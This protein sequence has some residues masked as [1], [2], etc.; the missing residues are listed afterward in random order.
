M[1]NTPPICLWPLFLLHSTLISFWNS[2]LLYFGASCSVSIVSISVSYL[3]HLL[4]LSELYFECFVFQLYLHNYFLF[5]CISNLCFFLN[6]PSFHPALQTLFLTLPPDQLNNAC[7]QIPWIQTHKQDLLD[8]ALVFEEPL[9]YFP[10]RLHDFTFPP[11]VN[12][13]SNFSTSSPTLDIFRFAFV[14]SA[15]ILMVTRWY[16]TVALTCTFLMISDAEHTFICLLAF[17]ILSPEK[18]HFSPFPIFLY[19]LFDFLVVGQ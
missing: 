10:R 18:W 11:T 19:C 17:C 16:F 5:T 6:P 3:Y 4:F 15:A 7:F 12:S 9:W 2:Y 13:G 1:E 14:L 8:P